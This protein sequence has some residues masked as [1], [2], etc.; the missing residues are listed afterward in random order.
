MAK[1][2]IMPKLGLTMEEGVINRWLVKEG[3]QVEKGD[4]LFE[5]ET[6]KVNMEVESPASGVL[7][8]IIHREG[9]TIPITQTVAYIGK[10]GEALPERV[11]DGGISPPEPGK[12]VEQISKT[13]ASGADR[14]LSLTGEVT[15]ATSGSS[16]MKVSPLARKL[17]QQYEIDLSKI[18]GT[19]P[20]GRIVKDDVERAQEA[21]REVPGLTVP[22]RVEGV[23][24]E[25]VVARNQE[26]VPLSRMRRT[27]ANR[28]LESTQNKPHFFVRQEI[29]AEELVHLRDRLLPVIEKHN[30]QRVSYTDIIIKMA[31]RALLEFPMVNAYF[32]GDAIQ[33][34]SSVHIGLAVAL[35]QG[36]IVPVIRD[37]DKKGLADITAAV[38]DLSARARDGKLLPEEISGGTFTVSN[39]GMYGVDDFS[40]VINPP[41]SA[42]LACGAIRKKPYFDGATIVPAHLFTLTLSADH[43]IVDGAVAAHFMQFLKT[44]L[45]EP[46]TLLV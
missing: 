15:T 4:V 24:P 13:A 35:D 21:R 18:S 2:V 36:L 32:T 22:S 40:A 26:A 6:D 9:E 45:E 44:L 12:A 20:G 3:D 10:K 25:T 31:A 14:A 19:G 7:L 27:I 41:E 33:M 1:S 16:R 23:Q 17:A 11:S 43:R 37:A 5:V 42:I 8:K 28:M 39:L 38:R 29:Y 30:G 46:L 34:N